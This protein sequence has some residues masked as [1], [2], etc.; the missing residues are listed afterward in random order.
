LNQRHKGIDAICFTAPNDN[1]THFYWGFSVPKLLE[2]YIT[3]LQGKLQGFE[4]YFD[5]RNGKYQLPGIINQHLILQDLPT[6]LQ[7]GD[8]YL[9]WFK[10]DTKKPVLMACSIV[11]LDEDR[12]S[13]MKSIETVIG[14]TNPDKA[15]AQHP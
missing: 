1:R 11:L 10:V 3:P 5:V 7:P 8:E 9:L 2:W 12:E 15:G 14:L 6:R 4:D 13:T